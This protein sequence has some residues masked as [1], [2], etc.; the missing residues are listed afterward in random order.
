MGACN[1]C[2]GKKIN[3]SSVEGQIDF[4]LYGMWLIDE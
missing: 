4:L 3:L 1:S 2:N